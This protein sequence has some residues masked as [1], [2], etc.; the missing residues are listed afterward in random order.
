[1]SDGCVF[2][3]VAFV[4]LF[5]R[6]YF[7]PFLGFTFNLVQNFESVFALLVLRVSSVRPDVDH[8]HE[9]EHH[10]QD[11]Q[12]KG[13]VPHVD[14]GQDQAGHATANISRVPLHNCSVSSITCSGCSSK[15]CSYFFFKIIARYVLITAPRNHCP[16]T[17][18]I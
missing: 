16:S 3:F 11:V 8:G 15:V 6:L 12:P 9:T 7:F 2:H 13:L 14:A 17:I 5:L 4:L 10:G 18:L 1:M